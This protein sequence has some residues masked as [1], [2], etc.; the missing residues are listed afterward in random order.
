MLRSRN[1]SGVARI[2]K[3]SR[4]VVHV[5]KVQNSVVDEEWTNLMESS[6]HFD[7][8]F[9]RVL[10]HRWNLVWSMKGQRRLD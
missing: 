7:H 6:A 4:P 5:S 10:N 3:G 9:D 1:H 8:G 2:E